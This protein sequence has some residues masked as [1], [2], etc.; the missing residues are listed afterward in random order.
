MIEL[1]EIEFTNLKNRK[2]IKKE[3]EEEEVA[4]TGIWDNNKSSNIYITGGLEEEGR[5]NWIV[6]EIVAEIFSKF[7]KTINP[8]TPESKIILNRKNPKKF[9]PKHSI[10]KLLKTKRQ[11]KTSWEQPANFDTHYA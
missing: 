10:I 2:K 7:G 3:E 11:R 9:M 4:L 5:I 8:Q 6:K 1:V